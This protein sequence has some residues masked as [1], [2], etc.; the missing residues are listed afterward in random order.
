MLTTILAAVLCLQPAEFPSYEQ[1]YAQSQRENRPLL[2]LVSARW[3]AACQVMKRDTLIPMRDQK[4]FRNA[5]VTI[6]DVDDQPQIAS[7][8]MQGNTLPQL[9]LIHKEPTGWKRFLLKGRQDRPQILDLL[10]RIK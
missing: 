6:V 8:L 4:E 10:K 7:Q 2:V 3:C 1:A 9:V 5:V